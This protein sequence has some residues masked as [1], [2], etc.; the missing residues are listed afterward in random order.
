MKSSFRIIALATL[1][2]TFASLSPAMHA[3]TKLTASVN[4]PFPFD[5]GTKH[6][7]PGVYA[8]KMDNPNFL[9]IDSRNGGGMAIV[10]TGSEPN[11]SGG[12]QVI[13]RKYGDR[14]FLAEVLLADR[15]D[16]ITVFE[17]KAEKRAANREQVM[18]GTAP[19]QVALALLPPSAFGN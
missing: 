19:T 17:S 10:Q 8:L 18:N 9:L 7:A 1:V 5:Y 15:G 4:V 11:S 16:R 13:F 6:Y 2:A 14:Y 3:Q 12:N